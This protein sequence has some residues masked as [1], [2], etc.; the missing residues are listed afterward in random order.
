MI[1]ARDEGSSGG[2]GLSN[3]SYE[4]LLHALEITEIACVQNRST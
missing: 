1:A 4:Q 2:I 3:V